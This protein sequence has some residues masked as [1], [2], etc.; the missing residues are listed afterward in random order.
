VGRSLLP[1]QDVAQ[2]AAATGSIG[3]VGA[4][5]RLPLCRRIVLVAAL[6]LG[7]HAM[8]DSFAV[9]RLGCRGDRRG[10][11]LSV[12]AEVLV[13]LF[14]G[15]RL[16]DR[17]APAGAAMLAAADPSRADLRAHEARLQVP[18]GGSRL[19]P[20]LGTSHRLRDRCPAGLRSRLRAG[21]IRNRW[22]ERRDAGDP[23]A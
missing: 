23:P 1:M 15:R 5:L 11:S 19:P 12:A 22:E 14:I 17:F 4:L 13:F 2:P 18:L 9:I 20:A 7:S 8:H 21:G 10:W 3:G 6:I 16:L